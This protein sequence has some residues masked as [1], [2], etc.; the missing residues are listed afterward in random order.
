MNVVLWDGSIMIMRNLTSSVALDVRRFADVDSFRMP[1]ILGQT[2]SIPLMKPQKFSAA[3]AHLRLPQCVVTLQRSFPRIADADWRAPGDILVVPM[4]RTVA[5]QAN[6]VHLDNRSM[7]L[8]H[9]EARFHL[10][11][12]L[13]NLFSAIRFEFNREQGGGSSPSNG[14][15]ILRAGEAALTRLQH[16]I[17]DTLASASNAPA[18]FA[19]PSS[20]A[21]IQDDLLSAVDAVLTDEATTSVTM[22]RSCIHYTQL[23]ARLDEFMEL[24]PAASHYSGALAQQCG[25]SPRTLH[26]AVTAVRGM[27]LHRYIRLRRLWRVRHHLVKTPNVLVRDIAVANGLWHQGEFASAY[28]SLFGETPTATRAA[29]DLSIRA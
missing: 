21:S 15:Q 9:R 11:E 24:H 6:G 27:S 18:L 1:G 17:A 5:A 12:P 26:S 25:A 28:R 20:A 14:L 2:S 16:T 19:S 13:G 8:V 23:V 29:R 7:L 4:E 10:T 3:I 22:R